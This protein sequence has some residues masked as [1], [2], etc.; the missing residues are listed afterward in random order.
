MNDYPTLYKNALIVEVK[1]RLIEEGQVRIEKCLNQLNDKEIW[2]RPNQ[3][4]N[5]IGNLVLH[6]CGNVRQWI[7]TGLA[8][9]ADIRERDLEFD[10]QG[11]LP[12][13][14]LIT[15]LDI[16]MQEVSR[17]L[18]EMPAETILATKN[19]QGFEET[20]LTV[21][22]HV[23]EHFSYHVGQITYITKALKDIDMQ[24]YSGLDL[25]IKN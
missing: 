7:L 12:V 21:L 25:N 19:V 13:E 24:Y 4:S 20:G 6:L 14:T 5:S 11:P 22:I 15:T 16:L 23:V 9:Q 1:R 10:E 3:N 18:D 2:Y 17:Y 8:G